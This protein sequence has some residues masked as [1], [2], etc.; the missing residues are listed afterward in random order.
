MF[1]WIELVLVVVEEERGN[2]KRKTRKYERMNVQTKRHT[3]LSVVTGE[4][5]SSKGEEEHERKRAYYTNVIESR[6]LNR[7]YQEVVP[8]D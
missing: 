7:I 2:E 3:S 8:E 5:R 1:V 6:M 4:V